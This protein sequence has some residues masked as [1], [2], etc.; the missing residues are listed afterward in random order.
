MAVTDN[1]G[2]K[3]PKRRRDVDD[4]ANDRLPILPNPGQVMQ[5]KKGKK[6]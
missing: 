1:V 6:D 4:W 3:L 5:Q 2:P